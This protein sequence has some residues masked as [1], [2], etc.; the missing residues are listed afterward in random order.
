MSI[1]SEHYLLPTN[2]FAPRLQ[3]VMEDEQYATKVVEA[4]ESYEIFDEEFRPVLNQRILDHFWLREIGQD[5]PSLFA[6]YLGRRLRERMPT[7]NVVFEQLQTTDPLGNQDVHIIDKTTGETTD[8]ATASSGTTQ[9]TSST[10][11]SNTSATGER[12]NNTN[13][14]T[15]SR[16]LTS[17]NPNTSMTAERISDYY[18]TGVFTDGS[19]SSTSK[20]T[21]KDTTTGTTTG[22]GKSTASSTADN[23]AKGTSLTDYVHRKYGREGVLF[24]DALKAYVEGYNN[25]LLLVFDAIEPCFTEFMLDHYNGY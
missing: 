15:T 23:K 1:I 4:L 20:D 24:S 19:S 2:T 16:N 13:A 12:G 10:T 7:I 17:Q 11:N 14:T 21:S 5:T 9:N 8:T 3:Q 22:T 6:F 25:A 18:D